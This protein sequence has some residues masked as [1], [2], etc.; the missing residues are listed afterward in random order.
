MKKRLYTMFAM[1]SML[2][3]LAVTSAQAHGADK[4]TVDIPFDFQI[5]GQTLSAGAYSVRQLSQ[6]VMIIE[7]ADGKT[8]AIAQTVATVQ[9]GAT[10]KVMKEKLV[11]HQYGDQHFLSQVWMVRDGDGRELSPSKAERQ[12]ARDQ[13]LAMGGAKART[14]EVVVE[15]R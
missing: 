2:F 6:N 15:A 9:A 3:A 8:R 7:S 1:L 11:F 13:K 5:E 12:A 4:L 14:T 10:E